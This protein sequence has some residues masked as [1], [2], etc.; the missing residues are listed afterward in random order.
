MSRRL[1][2]GAPLIA[3]TGG[4][5]AM[6]V[7]S[8]AL[9]EQAAQDVL[10]SAFQSA[11][12]RCSALRVLYVQEDAL[13]SFQKTLFGAMDELKIGDPWNMDTDIGP[14][15][16]S[17]AARK[18]CARIAA[19]EK[20]GRALKTSAA[21]RGLFAPPT[22]IRVRGIEDVREE[23]FGPV[24]HLASFRADESGAV[25]DAVNKSGFGLTFGLHSRIDARVAG[26]SAKARAGNLYVNRNQI[27]AVVGSQP[28]GGEGLS[29][30]GPKAGGDRYVRRFCAVPAPPQPSE[31]D[32]AP[33]SAK[34]QSA[35]QELL[36]NAAATPSSAPQ[37]ESLPGPVGEL[38]L[39]SLSPRGTVLCLG[40]GEKAAQAQAAI[41]AKAGCAAAIAAEGAGINLRDLRGF[42]AVLYWGN[43]G[44]KIAEDLAA[45][46]GE[47]IPLLTGEDGAMLI[48]E[49]HLCVNTAAAGGNAALWMQS[50]E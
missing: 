36:N 30:T 43:N 35:V 14:L 20:S 19:A 7:D 2:P 9:P 25:I 10:H 1:A 41:A 46:D 44:R 28:F 18:I 38:N 34:R 17:A 12:Q 15:I 40:P 37:T 16:D 32:S 33:V 50:E 42:A 21:P 27:G 23:I 48:R 39:L 5:N 47:I 11:G 26:L 49:R 29:G 3:E 13:P 24:L 4:I 6:I 45:R 22:V 31:P 8:T